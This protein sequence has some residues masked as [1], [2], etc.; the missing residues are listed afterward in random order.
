M[1]ITTILLVLFF[2]VISLLL[3]GLGKAAGKE[4]PP[5]SPKP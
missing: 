2:T 4:E 5:K 1:W 3:I